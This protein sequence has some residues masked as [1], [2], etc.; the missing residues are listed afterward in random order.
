MVKIP[1][2]TRA[3]L[4]YNNNLFIDRMSTALLTTEFGLPRLL[5]SLKMFL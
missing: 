5:L 3:T 1:D 4:T 2:E